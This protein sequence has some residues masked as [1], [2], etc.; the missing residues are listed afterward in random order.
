MLVIRSGLASALHVQEGYIPLAWLLL[1]LPPTWGAFYEGSECCLFF[2]FNLPRHES[3]PP[4][5]PASEAPWLT[6][7]NQN[8]R[9]WTPK[10]PRKPLR[11]GA[12]TLAPWQH[13]SSR[14]VIRSIPAETYRRE[15]MQGATKPASER[16]GGARTPLV[17]CSPFQYHCYV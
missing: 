12:V 11:E 13:V 2:V 7:A 4:R 6:A 5:V 14:P 17:Q 9:S 10:K 3:R 15:V 8:T 16:G 1:S